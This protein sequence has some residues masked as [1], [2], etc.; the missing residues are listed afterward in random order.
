MLR[1]V[2]DE[3]R[4]F[5]SLNSVRFP[6]QIDR[7]G[8]C[9]KHPDNKAGRMRSAWEFTR[10]L[11]STHT[12]SRRKGVF[13]G[14]FQGTSTV[15]PVTSRRLV[16]TS[17]RGFHFQRLGPFCPLASRIKSCFACFSTWTSGHCSPSGKLNPPTLNIE[18]LEGK[19]GFSLRWQ[20]ALRLQSPRTE[21]I[22]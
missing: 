20:L 15:H 2:V 7:A 11:R 13:K 9:G 14:V 16:R 1:R 3:I 8:N 10:V 22:P 17:R 12:N 21:K 18:E 4:R 6:K 19:C 5:H